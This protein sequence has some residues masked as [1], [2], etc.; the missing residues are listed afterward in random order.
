MDDPC[1]Q[2]ILSRTQIFC[3]KLCN[4]KPCCGFSQI[5]YVYF[6]DRHR[7]VC[8]RRKDAVVKTDDLYLFRNADAAP[9]ELT[10]EVESDRTV[11]HD[12]RIAEVGKMLP[13]KGGYARGVCRV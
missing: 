1:R 6:N 8:S 4:E 12:I 5:C 10:Q 2:K 7:G 3:L 13:D 9:G 11:R